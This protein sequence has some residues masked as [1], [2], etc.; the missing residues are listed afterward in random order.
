VVSELV[1]GPE[2]RRFKPGRGRR[3]FKGTTSV[4]GEVKLSAPCRENLKNSTSMAEIL[5]RQNLPV[6]SRQ[7]SPASLL[8]VSDGNC[9][10]SLVVE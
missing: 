1:I 10:R 9:L 2:I 6:I 3:I 4:G 7:V 5:S 8:G